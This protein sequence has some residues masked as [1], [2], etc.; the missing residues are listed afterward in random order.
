M[1]SPLFTSSSC[2]YFQKGRFHAS[3]ASHSTLPQPANQTA[4]TR[5]IGP[6]VHINHPTNLTHHTHLT[7]HTHLIHQNY[8]HLNFLHYLQPLEALL[9]DC[10]VAEAAMAVL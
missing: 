7:Y 6:S 10:F 3:V 1:P 9:T 2:A 8:H 5:P 4:A